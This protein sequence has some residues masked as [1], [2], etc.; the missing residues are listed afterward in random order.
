MNKKFSPRLRDAALAALLLMLATLIGFVFRR[1][2]FHESNVVIMFIFSVLLIARFTTGYFF[3]IAA[4]AVALLLFNW[5][6]TEPYYTLKVYDVTYFITFAIMAVTSV[7]TGTLTTKVK[8]A[9]EES[10]ARERESR[11]LYR[12]MTRLTDAENEAAIAEI[13]AEAAGEALGCHVVCVCCDEQTPP[14]GHDEKEAPAEQEQVYLIAEKSREP[15]TLRIPT[16]V[17]AA[18]TPEQSGML[19]AIME[20]A[21]LALERLQSLKEQARSREEM[22]RERYRGN[23]LR[24]IS[25]DLR[26]P[27]AGIMGT[28]E[29]LMDAIARDDARYA[30]VEDI[31]RD[32]QW[33]HG[34][35]E[36]ILNL[37]RLQDG[38]LAV[39]RQPEVVEEVIG[40]AVT[41]MEKRLRG[42]CIDVEM[43]EQ[44]LMADM[45]ARLIHQVLTNLLDNAAKH[46]SA[47][48][49]ISVSVSAEKEKLYITVADRGSGIREE[50]LPHIFQ[51]FYTTAGKSPDSVRGVGLGLAICQSIV[52]AHGGTIW[53]ENREGGGA[54][55]TFTLPAR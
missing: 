52:E 26:T 17:C 4:S 55:F 10:A 19:H 48:R 42:R 9:A 33:L 27:L 6:F 14:A 50:D 21:A 8:Q 23:L 29:M 46:T 11:A 3:G 39:N 53:A 40:A 35:V 5:F 1:C 36:N 2:G 47:E 13:L 49:P 44:L 54:A 15:L 16:A 41:M 24:A 37:T 34:M 20:S 7:V 18:M 43:P 12:L 31:Y 28:S 51:M 38:K 25:H 45:D 30:P 32:A 22:T